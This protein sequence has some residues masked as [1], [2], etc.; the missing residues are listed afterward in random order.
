ML[1][2]ESELLPFT[3]SPLPAGPWLVFAPHADD[4][5]FGMGGTLLKA[6][7]EGLDTHVVVVTD[8]A[9]GGDADDLVD[10]RRQEI[11]KAGDLLGLSSLTF[12]DVPDREVA[13]TN[14]QV[15]AAL[16]DIERLQARTVFFPAPL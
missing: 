3:I 2:P 14:E 7:E 10:T 9:L 16:A 13:I 11:Q 15:E 4:E 8:G 12:W 5:T 6:R 1:H